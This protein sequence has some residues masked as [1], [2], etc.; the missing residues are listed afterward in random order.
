MNNK[1]SKKILITGASGYIGSYIVENFQPNDFELIPLVR[2]LPDYFK[3]WKNKFN[4]IECDL[5]DIDCLRKSIKEIDFII[6]LAALNDVETKLNP[7]KA[8]LVNGMGTRNI[9]TIAQEVGCNK[10]I[11][12]STLQVYGKELEGTIN[13]NTPVNLHNDYAL[14]HYLAEQYCKMFHIAHNMNITIFRPSNIVGSPV[15]VNVKRWEL[16]PNCF[17]KS[18]FENNEIRLRSSGKQQRDFINL[19]YLL[20]SLIYYINNFERGFHIY[21]ISS[22]NTFSIS[23]IA[24]Q[25]IEIG[26]EFFKTKNELV[27][28]NDM[29]LKPN[30]FRVINN[31]LGPIKKEKMKENFKVEINKILLLLMKG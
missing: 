11:Y 31:L 25:V 16:V 13:I 27:Y 10:F 7:E 30:N 3:Y 14:T 15:N 21:N 28:E 23:E 22:E 8:L 9:L 18:I 2:R 29:P 5:L 1:N 6:H 17:C 12:I 20:K 24:E 19:S 4:L 26:S